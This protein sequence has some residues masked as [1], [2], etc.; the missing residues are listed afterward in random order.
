MGTAE[1]R[2]VQAGIRDQAELLAKLMIAPAIAYIV[3]MIGFPFLMAIF[4][5]VSDATTGDPTLRIIGF[6]NY[7]AILS[8]PV[9]RLALKNTFFFAFVSQA[10][11]I[12][13]S[14]I[15]AASLMQEFRGKWLARFLV[16][17]PWTA[18]IALGTIGWLWI[19]DS[20]FS[21]I[22]W[23]LRNAGLLGTP[24]ALLGPE[25]NMYWLGRSGLAMASVIFV[26]VWRLLPLAT[27]IQLAGLSSIPRD[28]LESAEIDGAAGWRR[29]V[30][31]TIPLTLPIIGI[32][33]LFGLIFTFTDMAVVY[34]LTRGGPVHSTQ[35]LSTWTFFKGIQGGDLAQGAAISLF[36]F[37]VLAGVATLML[38][39][40]RR[41]E[42]V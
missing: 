17:L 11:V 14:R 40:A 21:P 29:A 42:V 36:L 10:L 22:D 12:V 16:M 23:I 5:S 35:V 1:E 15:L 31:I 24:G 4:Y 3:A 37:P 20:I 6:Q 7:A 41:T 19:L 32:A 27:V 30:E 34:V 38:R 18:P 9:F 2:P 8:D 26:H 13:F 28:L 39:L 33:F 25:T